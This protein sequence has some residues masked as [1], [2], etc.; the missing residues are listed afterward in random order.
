MKENE[1]SLVIQEANKGIPNGV[2]QEI[3]ERIPMYDGVI[4]SEIC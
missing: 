2:A 4:T 3:R 1:N